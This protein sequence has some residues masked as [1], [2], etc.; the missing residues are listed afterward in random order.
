MAAQQIREPIAVYT[1]TDGTPLEDGYIFIGV[2]GLNPK[3]NPLQAYWD[4]DLTVPATNIRT[5]GGYASNNGTPG[6]LFV[7]AE[8]S[9]LVKNKAG[10]IIYSILTTAD[11][12]FTTITRVDTIYNQGVLAWSATE[13]YL[14]DVS[15]AQSQGVIW[16]SLE[17]TVGSPNVN[18]QPYTNQDKWAPVGISTVLINAVNGD[19]IASQYNNINLIVDATTADATVTVNAPVIEEGAKINI[20]ANGNFTITIIGGNG[21]PTGGITLKGDGSNRSIASVNGAWVVDT[22][23]SDIATLNTASR[24]YADIICRNWT[25]LSEADGDLRSVCWSESLKLYV[26]VGEGAANNVQYSSDGINWTARTEADGDLRSICFSESIGRFVAVGSASTNNIQYSSD[27]V[28]WAAITVADG[29]LQSVCWSESLGIY[30]AVGTAAT[31]NVQY[32]SDGISWT[33]VTIS[34]TGLQ[35]VTFSESIGKFVAV[36]FGAANNIQYSSDGINWTGVV[37]SPG[38]LLDVCWAESLKLYV[39]VGSAATN[40]IQYSSDGITWTALAVSTSGLAS[41]CFSESIGRLVAVSSGSTKNIRYSSDALTWTPATIADG[42]LYG[43]TVSESLGR[44]VVVGSA[45]TN[46]VQYTD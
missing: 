45:A 3:T 34:T 43:I 19:T 7:S 42:D 18:N 25:A 40:N 30:V 2:E 32:S 33:Q 38:T 17:G 29:D 1:D 36:G 22:I 21:I 8:Y 26:A 23:S 28:T 20:V 16:K 39:A 44:F 37:I 6:R 24:V 27:G 13:E 35:G 41:I 10:E 5:K 46:N 9:I 15:F 31:N 12:L 14:L 11:S 4:V